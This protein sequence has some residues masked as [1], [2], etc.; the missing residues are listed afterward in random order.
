MTRHTESRRGGYSLLELMIALGLLGGLM[1][2]AWSLIGSYRTAEQR[3][4]GQANRMQVVR[5]AREMLE[6]D[7][8]HWSAATSAVA[9]T[10]PLSATSDS[11]RPFSIR[12]IS[13]TRFRGSASELS[14][15][16]LPSIDP[17]PWLEEVTSDESDF[18]PSPGGVRSSGDSLPDDEAR[19]TLR[20]LSRPL[21]PL[22]R[23]SLRYTLVPVGSTADGER[24]MNLRRQMTVVGG[25]AFGALGEVDSQ[26]DSPSG[27]VLSTADL[28]RAGD[29]PSRDETAMGSGGES[30]MV[31]GLVGARFRYSGGKEWF[32]SWDET[33]RG[34]LPR[35]IELSFD[36]PAA[37]NPNEIKIERPE[38][39]GRG[40]RDDLAAGDRL[41]ELLSRDT[42]ESVLSGTAG[43]GAGGGGA[44]GDT[45]REIRIVIRVTDGVAI[46]PP[47]TSRGLSGAFG[48][49][50]R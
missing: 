21:G 47:S 10:S 18:E 19:S 22:Q 28:Y 5:A 13:T 25:E 31:R 1:A 40:G 16:M 8:D 37:T 45:G 42:V 38:E 43:G 48:E 2:L 7:V 9:S 30:T 3:G 29:A 46:S 41:D 6:N 24:L 32:D 34:G 15:E 20:P 23:V 36:L 44:G 4:W 35:A 39:M 12:P 14:I 33:S 50:D 17:L 49:G 11:I 27:R 26:D